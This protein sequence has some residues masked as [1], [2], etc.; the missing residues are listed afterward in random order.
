[1]K[2]DI[3]IVMDINGCRRMTKKPPKLAGHERSVLMSIEVEDEVFDYS[4]MK[5]S[6]TIKGDD[7]V[8]PSLEVQLLHANEKL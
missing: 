7:V 2:E 6:L 3:Y 4:F 1:M 8:E 5:T